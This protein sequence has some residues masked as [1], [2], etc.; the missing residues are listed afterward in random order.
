MP[1]APRSIVS[2][3]RCVEVEGAQG[4]AQALCGWLSPASVCGRAVPEGMGVVRWRL[5]TVRHD[6]PGVK[7][8][9]GHTDQSL[10]SDYSPIAVPT[11][12][13]APTDCGDS[14]KMGRARR[15]ER[16]T[17]EVW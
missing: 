2:T 15:Q 14:G 3:G 12:P 17:Q 11:K 13:P 7:S 16:C 8:Y 4:G 6:W 10:P 1:G 9:K 5:P